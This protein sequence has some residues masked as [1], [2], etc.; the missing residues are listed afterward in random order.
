[1]TSCI[2]SIVNLTNDKL[3]IGSAI[4]WIDRWRLHK[5]HLNRNTHHS[6]LLQRSWNIHGEENFAFNIIEF[7]EKENLLEREKYW[8]EKL[9]VCNPQLGY[10]L[11]K[12]ARNRLGVKASEETRLKLS[13]SH[14]GKKPSEET[15]RKMSESKI[16]NK[17]NTGR[18]QTQE[19]IEKRANSNKGKKRS[20]ESR[21]KMSKAQQGKIFSEETRLKMSIAAQNRGCLRNGPLT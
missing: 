11:C 13:L 1:M 14:Q 18:K 16:G 15:R 8:I 4:D 20:E 7:V 19:H 10:N 17:Y 21:L 3:Y 5:L 6:I 9:D 12:V 2:Y